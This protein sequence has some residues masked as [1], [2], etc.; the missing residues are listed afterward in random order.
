MTRIYT[1]AHCRSEQS[2]G[3]SDEEADAAFEAKYGRQPDP[4]MDAL[5]C[6]DC[7]QMFTKWEATRMMTRLQLLDWLGREDSS[8][9]GECKGPLLDQ[10]IDDRLVMVRA[11][12]I[13]SRGTDYHRVSLT[14]AG[15]AELVKDQNR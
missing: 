8:A 11:D 1:C 7:F 2:K 13:P 4:V 15:W 3:W 6:D 10:L 9:Y 5:I 14:E 12:G